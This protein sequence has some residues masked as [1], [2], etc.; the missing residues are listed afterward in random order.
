M[1]TNLNLLRGNPGKRKLNANEP[2]PEPAIPTCPSHL[3]DVGKKEWRRVT[4][5]L[6][7]LRNNLEARSRRG[8]RLLRRVQPVG[9]GG[10]PNPAIRTDLQSSQW[11]P[12]AVALPGDSAHR[13]RSDESV[14]YRVRNDPEL[15]QPRECVKSQAERAVR[16]IPRSRRRRRRCRL[17]VAS[18]FE[19]W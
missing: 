12:H 7:A 16:T 13:A 18:Y 1:P 14:S 11:I 6:L 10:N 2:D 5:E 3:N 9:R 4:K 19:P 15:A 17:N 8:R